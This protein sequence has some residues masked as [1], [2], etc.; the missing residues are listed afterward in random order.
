MICVAAQIS[1]SAS[2]IVATPLSAPGVT[3]TW[4]PPALYS[5]GVLLG[6]LANEKKGRSIVSRWSRTGMS[7]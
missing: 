1:T 6:V 4:T 5:M 7:A 2:Q 3:F